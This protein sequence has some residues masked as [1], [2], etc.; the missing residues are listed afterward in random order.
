MNSD[1]NLGPDE[2]RSYLK[3]SGWSPVS[4]GDFAELWSLPGPTEEVVLVPM[5]PGAPDFDKRTNILLRDL[6]RIEQRGAQDVHTSIATVY[7]DVTDLRASHPTLIDGSIPL[8]AG[9]ELF[10][11]AKRLRMASAAATIRRQSHYRSYPHR[12]RDQAREVRLGQTRRGSYVVPIISQA[13]AP[14]DVYAPQQQ[15]LDLQVEETLFDRRVTATM[16]RA[17][18]VLEDMTSAHREPTVSEI[19]DSVGEG[20][21]YQLC[22]AVNKIIQTDSVAALDVEFRWSK[23]AP[24]P[25]G[26]S[27]QVQFNDVAIETVGRISDQLRRHSYARKNV[28]YGIITDLSRRPEDATGKVG[29]EALVERRRRVVWIELPERQY[30]QA[31]NCHDTGTPVRV[32]GILHSPP[33][34]PSTMDV[35]DFGPDPALMSTD[36]TLESD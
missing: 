26:A 30:H 2:I 17:L 22:Q 28:I 7:H 36:L 13:R 5:K 4:G 25:P 23:V 32:L 33:S 21:S 29:I 8:D 34:G 16:S 20:V 11:S 19:S 1:L 15:H 18:S 3:V 6:E 12:A 10:L 27:P 31:V 14:E 9:Y 35:S 24:P